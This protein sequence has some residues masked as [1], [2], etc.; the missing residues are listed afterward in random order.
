MQLV[1][2][3]PVEFLEDTVIIERRPDDNPVT[4]LVRSMLEG[5]VLGLSKIPRIVEMYA[6]RLQIQ[7]QMT[8]QIG[9]FLQATLQPR[10][11]AVIVEGAH[12]CAMM[13]GVRQSRARM[14]TST[15]PGIYETDLRLRNQ[16]M[17]QTGIPTSAG[18]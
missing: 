16:L 2:M 14:M 4:D 9:D 10:G 5:R 18:F 6:R 17:A 1:T 11:V 3:Q 8:Q 12:M 13:R 7:E 15:M